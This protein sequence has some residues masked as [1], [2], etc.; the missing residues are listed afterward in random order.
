MIRRDVPAA[1]HAPAQWVLISQIE[2]AHLAGRLAEH[3]GANGFAALE[4]RRELLWAIRHHDDGW[5]DW[6]RAPNVDPARRVPRAFTEMEIADSLAIWTGS[7]NAAAAAGTLEA[8]LVAGHFCAL[9]QRASAW[10]DDAD[11]GWADVKKFV[12]DYDA[13]R[14]QWLADWQ[15]DD[16]RA[17][18]RAVAET[19]LAQLQFFD[20]LS[21]WFCCAEPSGTEVAPTPAGPELTLAPRGAGRVVLS[22]WPLTVGQLNLEVAGRTVPAGNYPSREALAAAPSQPVNLRFE[23][24]AA[25]G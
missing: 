21:L 13:R 7:I 2:H 15:R 20:S 5:Q 22:P 25:A 19:A 23:L 16:P 8:Y 18:T 9:A 17:H 10:H 12:A 6:D 11:P 3:W 14:Q 4:P 24:R 1:D